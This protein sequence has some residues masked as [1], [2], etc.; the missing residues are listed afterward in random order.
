MP[1]FFFKIKSATFVR[2]FNEFDSMRIPFRQALAYLL[3][4]AS[5][6]A[7]TI[8]EAEAQGFYNRNAWKKHRN[9]LQ[10]GLGVSNFLGDIGGRD[11]I[12]S[13]FV[14]DLE[15]S[16]TKFAA[17]FNYLYYLGEKTALRTS[18][19]YAKVAGDDKLTQE[20]FR[21]NRNLNF[22][23]VIL[24]GGLGFEYQFLKEKIGNIYN[25]KSPT[26]KKLG[27]RSFSAG[28]YFFTGV[29]G[30]Y[31]NP[32]SIDPASGQPVELR[33]LKTEGQGLDGGADPYGIMSVA[34]PV[35]FGMRKSINRTIGF[36]LELAH[37]FTF[38]DYIDDVSTVYYSPSVLNAEVGPQAAYFSNPQLGNLWNR[39]TEPGQ[40]RGDATDRDGYMF[41]TASIYVQLESKRSFY[42]RNRVKR[43]KASF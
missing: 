3:L 21:N 22:E 13:N 28:F 34:I 12:G 40:Q 38:T 19:V 33:P 25:V 31:Y 30:F 11:Q 26:G 20:M 42:G 29:S 32:K 35:G 10:F 27:L 9:E 41:L 23:S 18:F 6:S 24:E 37:R 36:K 5:I 39:V 4:V 16:K 14:W 7:F 1:N 2:N 8:A 43:V 15:L 17:S